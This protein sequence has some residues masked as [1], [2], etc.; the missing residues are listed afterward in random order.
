MSRF[1]RLTTLQTLIDTGLVPIFYWPDVDAAKKVV[2]ACV[3]GGSRVVEFTNRGDFAPLVFLELSQYVA[4]T[5]P[6]VAFGV[7]SVVD[8]PTAALYIAYGADFVVAPNLVP[9]VARLC[10]RRRIPY[11]PGCGSVTEIGEAEELGVEIVK[12]FPNSS[13]GGPEFIKATLGPCP[14]TKILPTAVVDVTEDDVKAW[15]TA[16]AVSLGIG[17]RLINRQVIEGG[18]WDALADRVR[19]ILLWVREA[20]GQSVFVGLE[21]VGL[22]AQPGAEMQAITDWYRQ[23]FGFTAE[24]GNTH[25]LT[26]ETSS[27]RIEVMPAAAP[28]HTHVAIGVSNFEA[29]LE[30]LRERGIATDAPIL[31]P[32]FRLAYLKENDPAGNRV[33][34]IWRA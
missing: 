27:G 6:G 13:L 8:A 4:K 23:R 21:H 15:I 9:E 33:H 1:D 17:S 28:F 14:R 12:V 20:R 26:G 29:A 11:L 10:N 30:V 22:Y 31:N 25:L 19:R 7:G 34:I 18:D 24:I 3:A 16:G 32:G 2:D 5:Y